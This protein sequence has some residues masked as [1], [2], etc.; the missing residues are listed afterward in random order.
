MRT[1][2]ALFLLLSFA[3][4][5]V[6]CPQR[7]PLATAQAAILLLVAGWLFATSFRGTPVRGGLRLAVLAAAIIW[8]GFST[9]AGWTVYPFASY[10]ALLDWLVFGAVYF[11]GLQVFANDNVRRTILRALLL[12][13]LG[14]ALLA[15]MQF[16]TSSGR[17]L[18]FVETPYPELLG[19]FQ[20]R[21][22]FA[23]F[24]E[25]LVPISLWSALRD[26]ENRMTYLGITAA[27]VAAV[28]S[29][30]SRTG[31][32]LIL[33]EIATIFVIA[34]RSHLL[35]RNQLIIGGTSAATLIVIGGAVV[36]WAP[37]THRMALLGSGDHRTEI[38]ASA[39]SMIT[40][41]PWTG[42]GPG[43]FTTVYPAF[44]RFD[45]GVVV[46]YAHNDW[47][48]WAVEGGL[49]LLALLVAFAALHIRPAIRST[50]GLGVLA[51]FLHA[52][53]DFPFQRLG[54]AG[55]VFLMLAALSAQPLITPIGRKRATFRASP[56]RSTTSITSS[57]SL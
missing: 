8:V 14:V 49:P 44:A 24:V 51:V 34:F 56:A 53:V 40:S 17:F 2:V 32:V 37:L 15:V 19:P 5:T 21:N 20:N 52:L 12:F 1:A 27:L 13:G 3:T 47:L 31:T 50:W 22:N 10:S 6:W 23:A 16:P 54:V 33:I 30:S 55:W 35:P 48:Q 45:I 46:N 7:W 18:W 9:L 41:Q 26:S 4:L 38:F 28:A 57:T 29:G 39:L 42:F 36:S 43:T 11:L 25:L